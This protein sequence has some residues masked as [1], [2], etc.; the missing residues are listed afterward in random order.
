MMQESHEMK[1]HCKVVNERKKKIIFANFIDQHTATG[2]WW[3]RNSCSQ[4][5]SLAI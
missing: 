2:E 4:P 3:K 5:N 1:R